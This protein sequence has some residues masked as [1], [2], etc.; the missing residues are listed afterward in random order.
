[1]LGGVEPNGQADGRLTETIPTAQFESVSIMKLPPLEYA[2]PAT[3]SEAIALLAS[4]DG[5][6]KAIAGGQSLMPMLAFRMA[7]P[8]LLV[9]LRKLP[10]LREIKISADGVRLG[11]M[12]RWR[13][14]ED[15]AR[16]ASAHPLLRPRSRMWRIIRSATGAR[17]AAA[18]RMPIRQPKFPASSSP[19]RHASRSQANLAR[20][21]F[22]AARIFSR[23][24]DD[25]AGARR[26]HHRNPLSGLA[27]AAGAWDLRSSPAG[28][29]ISRSPAR[30]CSTIRT[31]AAR[32]A[33]PMW[34]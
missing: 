17:S 13:D 10:E 11:A 14:I 16:L 29:A 22:A 25:G 31:P 30:R 27:G 28:A 3:L 6:A 12:V 32:R 5:D 15:D 34:A 7:A 21:K 33:T 26:D 19:A 20:G 4:R 23:A 1:M 8:S 2:C 18:S 9:D 24:D